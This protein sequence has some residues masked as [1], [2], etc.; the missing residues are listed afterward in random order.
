MRTHTV[1]MYMYADI[2]LSG[3]ANV[4]PCGKKTFQK[5][6]II[7][8]HTKTMVLQIVHVELLHVLKNIQSMENVTDQMHL[9]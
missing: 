5:I 7:C 6:S 8:F 1:Y 9:S 4:L 2:K 3:D